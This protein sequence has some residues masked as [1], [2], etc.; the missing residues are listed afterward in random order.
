MT[1][2]P[3]RA[4]T[5]VASLGLFVQGVA[6]LTALLVPAFDAMLPFILDQTQMVPIHSLLHIAS[7]LV[8]F[9]LLTAGGDRGTR[10]FAVGFGLFYVAL[11]LS[12]AFAG[13]PHFLVLKPFDHPFHMVVGVTGVI[14]FAVEIVLKRT[15]SRERR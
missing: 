12:G 4:Y 11:G 6:T 8:G 7:G 15:A 10:A 14:A 2:S 5:L 9:A 1:I 3:T 13:Q